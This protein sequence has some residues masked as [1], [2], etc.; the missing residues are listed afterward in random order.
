MDKMKVKNFNELD[1]NCVSWTLTKVRVK[2]EL[3]LHDMY[4]AKRQLFILLDSSVQPVSRLLAELSNTKKVDLT[5]DSKKARLKEQMRGYR[6]RAIESSRMPSGGGVNFCNSAKSSSNDIQ[7]SAPTNDDAGAELNI[8]SDSSTALANEVS[9][10]PRDHVGAEVN[11]LFDSK[12][13]ARKSE[14]HDNRKRAHGNIS[15][16]LASDAS[17]V[18][19][20][21]VGEVDDRDETGDLVITPLDFE[22]WANDTPSPTFT[23]GQSTDDPL[24]AEEDPYDFVYDNLPTGQ[25]VLRKVKNC[26][27]CKAKRFQYEFPT[28]CCMNGKV[29]LTGNEIPD[30]LAIVKTLMEVFLHNP[31][32]QNFKRLGEM[33]SLD[34]VGIT[35]NASVELDQRRYNKPTASQV[36]AIW[37]EGNEENATYKRSIKIYDKN[38]SSIRIQ[39]YWGIYDPLSYPLFFPNGEVGWHDKILRK[40]MTSAEDDAHA[41][42]DTHAEEGEDSIE[43]ENAEKGKGTVSMR[44][45]YCYKLQIRLERSLILLGG[46][47]LQ[48]FVVDMY[49]KME[50]CRLDYHRKNQM[51]IRADLYQGIMDSIHSG[52][53]RASQTGKRIMLP[54]SFIGGPRDMQRRYLDAMALVQRFGKPDIFLTMTCNPEWDEIR[55]ELLPGQTAQD[56]PD[57]TAR[58]FRAKL[59]DLK[60]YLFGDSGKKNKK[61]FFGEVAA[62]VYVVEFHKRGLPHAHFLIILKSHCKILNPDQYD[63]IVCAEIPDPKRYPV[64]ISK[65]SYPVYRRRDNG[66]KFRVRGCDLDNRWVSPYNPHLLMRYNCHINVE[67]CSSIRAVKYLFKYIY[68]GH[69]CAEVYVGTRGKEGETI[70]EI[71]IFQ[72]ARWVGAPEA[73][74]RIFRFPLSEIKPSV[75]SLQLHTPDQQMV[76]YKDNDNLEN[77][78]QRD[79]V[80]RTM[81]TEFFEANKRFPEAKQYLYREFPEHFTWDE[82]RKVWKR[83]QRGGEIGRVIFAKISD[84]ERY[85]LRTLLNHRRGPESYEDLLMVDG[86]QHLTFQDAADAMGLIENDESLSECLYEAA[87]Y[88]MPSALRRLFATILTF[89]EGAK[90]RELWDRH[91]IDMSE[92]YR[93]RYSS[94]EMVEQRTLI[95]ISRYLESMGRHLE[96]YNLPE[97]YENAELDD[98][99][100]FQEVTDEERVNVSEEDLRAHG[101]LNPEQLS[102]FEEIMKHVT[103]KKP[104]AFFV[105]GP[106]GTAANNML[107][108]RT[109]HSR[110]KIHINLEGTP[111]CTVSKQSAIAELL[112]RATLIIWDEASMS[113]RQA[114]EALDR[115]LHDVTDSRHPF[116]GKIVVF[117]GDFRQVLP[118]VRRGTKAQIID[119]TLPMSPLWTYIKKR[120][121]T[122]NMRASSDPWFAQFL[123]N[124]GD[125]TEP[126]IGND[127]IRVP[128]E[129]II[130]YT[131]EE[132]S[133]NELIET[134]F[135]S[136]NENGHRTDYIASRAILS[137]KNE[138]VDKLNKHM[139]ESYPGEELI[140]HSIDTAV[141]DAR[142]NYPSEFLNSLTPNGLPPHILKLKKGCP[143][144]LLRNLDPANGLCNGTRLVCWNFQRNVID[145][146]ITTG[147]HVGKRIFI[148]RIPLSPADDD[149]FPFRFKRK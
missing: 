108:G 41:E 58:V 17:E 36:G 94:D 35:L 110:F 92:D 88:Q 10:V 147:G 131:T 145:A 37:V 103:E 105:D 14:M 112:R 96:N 139:I 56:W 136:L 144:I 135:P 102:A 47:L 146:E 38:D 123:L 53:V 29:E 91:F 98:H 26:T 63:K 115:T 18:P 104:G 25:I 93:R 124:V 95:D 70:D 31:Y 122:R 69:D 141:D 22:D 44:E 55:N 148:P 80:K 57:L 43:M 126:S 11:I 7:S 2:L 128:N 20:G 138:Y 68:K 113:K 32:A 87:T 106:G 74:W 61:P 40:N 83:R 125:G 48:Q 140:Y 120:K 86:I 132:E 13:A 12:K 4:P 5:S 67:I 21:E 107:R 109:A 130:P 45:Y 52:E 3:T 75:R 134:V 72:D 84:A 116:G 39:C 114:V 121:L 127:F 1:S 34:N 133:V 117:G 8:L 9:E 30:K 78:S 50:T 28:F 19:R 90:A 82:S 85:Y 77:V 149:L 137:T 42:D 24:A 99:G 16:A 62:H 97:L 101:S 65:D 54:G 111:M 64:L 15:T 73:V 118:V 33:Q 49:I 6:K 23:N 79:K 142:G 81:L 119:A 76:F 46:R 60:K 51:R 89:C 59:E 27:N 129:M 66:R 71:K 143:V 100:N